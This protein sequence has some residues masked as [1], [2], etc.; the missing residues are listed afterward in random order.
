[1][2]AEAHDV[3]APRR[4]PVEAAQPL[5][6]ATD[7][8]GHPVTADMARGLIAAVRTIRPGWKSRQIAEALD[9]V[10]DQDPV[11]VTLALIAAARNPNVTHPGVVASN[12]VWWDAAETYP[13]RPEPAP[14]VK[15]MMTRRERKERGFTSFL[16]DP[17]N[18]ALREKARADAIKEARARGGHVI[19]E[20]SLR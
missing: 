17:S 2:T 3:T 7:P 20:E 11:A 13:P 9:Q 19:T 12:G 5:T 10:R 18:A 8:T 16:D 1:M 15:P 6:F 4:E 14:V